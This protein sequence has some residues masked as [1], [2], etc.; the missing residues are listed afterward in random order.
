[1]ARCSCSPIC[2]KARAGYRIEVWD[3]V[4]DP[5]RAVTEVQD[6]EAATLQISQ[7]SLRSVLGVAEAVVVFAGLGITLGL[8]AGFTGGWTDR[9]IAREVQP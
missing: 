6:F 4:I 8:V 5:R 7:T 3:R 2:P 1:M 9:L